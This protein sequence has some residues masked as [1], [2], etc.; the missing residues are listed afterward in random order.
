M[1]KT[2]LAETLKLIEEHAPKLRAAGVTS[3]AIGDIELQLATPEQPDVPLDMEKDEDG[4]DRP[5]LDDPATFGRKKRVPGRQPMP[6][7]QEAES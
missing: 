3:L 2:D 7:D 1:T 4:D 5:P 6:R